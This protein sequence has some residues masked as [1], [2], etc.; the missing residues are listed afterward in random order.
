MLL[1]Q[2]FLLNSI[3]ENIIFYILHK[4][5]VVTKLAYFIINRFNIDPIYIPDV[6]QISTLNLTG[7]KSSEENE[8]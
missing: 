8:N 5:L 6:P 1:S 7:N 3:K 2:Y 4:L